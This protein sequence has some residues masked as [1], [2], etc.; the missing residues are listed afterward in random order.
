MAL[1][2]IYSLCSKGG[3]IFVMRKTR[4]KTNERKKNTN[5]KVDKKELL[6]IKKDFK[7]KKG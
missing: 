3:M 1:V 7:Q 4:E 2:K 5:R 6:K